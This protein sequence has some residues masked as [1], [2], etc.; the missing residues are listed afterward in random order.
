MWCRAVT[1]LAACWCNLTLLMASEI[2]LGERTLRFPDGYDVEVVA[3]P[4]L[5]ERPI[6]IARDERGRLYVTDSAGMSDKA[7][8]QL[9]EKPHRIRRLE[10]RDGDGRYDHATL[11]ADRMMFPEGC[12]WYEGALY[13]A[14]PPEIWKLTDADDDGVAERREVW[15]DGKTLTGCA[16]DLHG[17]YL[18][19][20]GWFYFCKGAFAEQKH[21]LPNGKPFVTRA[22]HI[23]RCRPDGS[24]LEPV[25][26]GGMDNPVGVAFLSTGERILSCTFFQYPAAGRR[27]GLIHAIYG[28]VY[29]KKHDSID[30]HK[31]TGDV[32]PVLVHQGPAAPAGIIAGSESL[33]G[34]DAA[35]HLFACYFNLHKVVE[36]VLIP[37]GATYQS[38]EREFLACDH[39][40]FHPTDV[41]ED[42]DGSL[43]IVD[44]GGWYKVCCPTS[45]I[46]RPD[47]LGAIYRVR[48]RGHPPVSDPLGTTLSWETASAHDLANRLADPRLFV[49][50][51]ATAA[52][53]K[54][55]PSAAEA[56]GYLIQQ[57]ADPA[58]R[59]RGVW[60][61]ALITGET[62]DTALRA[63]LTDPD[64]SVRHAAVHVVGLRRDP[65][66]ADALRRIIRGPDPALARAAAEAIGRL[67]SMDATADLFAAL[68]QLGEFTPDDTGAPSDA[69]VRI[70][71][72]S[73]I[74]ALLESARPDA[75]RSRLAAP[76]LS[77]NEHRAALVALDQMDQGRLTPEE[78][79]P[80]L[81]ASQP[82]LRQTAAWIVGHHPEWGPSLVA[83]FTQRLSTVTADEPLPVISLLAR[84]AKSPAIQQWLAEQVQRTDR[85]DV[86]RLAL[87]AMTDSGLTATPLEWFAALVHLLATDDTTLL[88]QAV[89]AARQWPQ[90]KGGHAGL[91]TALIE[92]GR[93]AE[94]PAAVR[95]DALLAAGPL[96]HVDP[97]LFTTLLTALAETQPMNER[98][99]AAHILGSAAL[100]PSQQLALAEAVPSIGPF[101][102]PKVLPAFERAPNAAL[103]LR[104]VDALKT[105]PGLRGLRTD[106]LKPLLDKYP[107]A[108]QEAGRS[109]L[110][111]LN[112]SAAEQA[113][114][115]DRLLAGVASGDAR[116]GHELFIGKKAQCINCHTL[117][118]LGGRLGP[119]LT[120]IGKVRTERDLLE[121]IVYPSASF[122]RGYEPVV[123]ELEDG[124]TITGIVTR[125]SR[126]E[127][128]LAIDPQKTQHIARREISEIHPSHVSLMPQGIDKLLSPQEVLDLVVFLKM[129]PR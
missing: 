64:P 22:S 21:T 91:K 27:D 39:P 71:E 34:G 103:G 19:H 50:R 81:D 85:P 124:R 47:V 32:M 100:T 68:S 30:E 86:Q 18:G 13:V 24:H 107:P 98:S 26:T 67:E 122:V 92:V 36:H 89:T 88:A 5:V 55:G 90:P 119:D 57:H 60:T 53:R 41:Y 114:H 65:A 94:V 7:D 25:L 118:Y 17:P 117:G 31:Q 61:L 29:G 23:F 127:V 121:A 93:R 15:Y 109:L 106:L 46:A 44:T 74:Y 79:L 72:H 97:P 2:T 33:F 76:N 120:N 126:D 56:V 69:P 125:E 20:D 62:A 38:T 54:L 63:A 59:R 83:Y 115:L 10:D 129:G 110:E 87:Q 40:D 116:R 113:A 52:L 1:T 3:G 112:A 11:F 105:S 8:R 73:L 95:L 78:V 82:I 49:R 111:E 77:L 16:N 128:V 102:L 42:A 4:P 35:D 51:R 37:Q 101:E 75:V 84:L 66:A 58:V 43:L 96:P 48:K 104:L 12:L 123:V 6:S 80:L 28:G 9:A 70:V 108:V 14:A 45:Q 99:A